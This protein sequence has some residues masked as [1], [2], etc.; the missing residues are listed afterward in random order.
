MIHLKIVEE[1]SA[2][3]HANITAT[4]TATLEFTK[5]S[6]LTKNGNCI[7]AVEATKG[8]KDLSDTFRRSCRHDDA[9]ISVEISSSGVMETIRGRGSHLL[10]L[11]H[12]HEM[13]IRKSAYVT[14]RTLMIG[15]NAAAADLSRSLIH[16]ITS[17]SAIIHIRL[18]SET[19]STV[20]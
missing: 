8:L 2:R 11:S 16:A 12:P 4:H 20:T 5:E 18:T 7:V 17:S 13:V 10:T 15:S 14:D 1:F 3:G 9:Q 6:L 19:Q